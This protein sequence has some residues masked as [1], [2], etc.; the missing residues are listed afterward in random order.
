MGTY[1]IPSVYKNGISEEQLKNL[2]GTW[3][4]ISN[5]FTKVGGYTYNKFIVK[6]NEYLKMLY[7]NIEISYN[8]FRRI[9]DSPILL[10][11]NDNFNKN[12]FGKFTGKC[13]V[14]VV[15]N[16]LMG[17]ICFYSSNKLNII[18]PIYDKNANPN[19]EADII[20][21]SDTLMENF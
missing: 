9:D 12:F 5:D 19:T 16:D 14:D 10:A 2:I 13:R 18:L 7:V 11:T 4:D 6:Y 1:N 8:Y 3:T 15:P 21:F 20:Y 17:L